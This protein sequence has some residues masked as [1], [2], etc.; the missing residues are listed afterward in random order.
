MTQNES[1]QSPDLKELEKKLDQLI[2][3]YNAVKSENELLKNRQDSLVREKAQLVE[4]TAL[5]RNRVE[6]MISRL[7][8][9]GQS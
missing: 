4:K 1:Y 6:A 9:M 2:D 5:A 3:R 8:T 7:R